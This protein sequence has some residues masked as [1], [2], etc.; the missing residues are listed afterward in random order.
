MIHVANLSC[1]SHLGFKD[2]SPHPEV[3]QIEAHLFGEI[4]SGFEWCS[5]SDISE[6]LGSDNSKKDCFA[7]YKRA[8]IPQEYTFRFV[9]TN[10]DDGFS[11]SAYPYLTNRTITASS[12]EC[13][14]YVIDRNSGTKSKDLNGDLAAF[15]W[16][17]S[18][19]TVNGSIVIPTAISA[20]DGTTYIYNGTEIPQKEQASS[21]GPRCMWMWAYKAPQ[22]FSSD[23]DHEMAAY[24]CPITVGPVRNAT[25]DTHV[26][27]DQLAKLAASAIALQGRST[28]RGNKLIWT[29][30]QLYPW[31]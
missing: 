8:E 29:Q 7:W 16:K 24:Q 15:S 1:Y 14:K 5:Y 23:T 6:V 28:L 31:G 12:G 19:G 10:P 25:R 17:Y 3:E 11:A 22:N 9:E 20:F 18:N 26:V 30:Y 21:C 27:D 13:Y 2:C 4:G